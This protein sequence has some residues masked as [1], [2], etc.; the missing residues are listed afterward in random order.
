L[1]VAP[2]VPLWIHPAARRVAG[3]AAARVHGDAVRSQ[4]VVGVTGTNGKSTVVHLAG[5]GIRK[6]SRG[7]R[8]GSSSPPHGSSPNYPT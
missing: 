8:H 7:N 3:L 6:S 5:V 2:G 4:R 1:D